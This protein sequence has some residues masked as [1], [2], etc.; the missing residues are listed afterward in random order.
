MSIVTEHVERVQSRT[1]APVFLMCEPDHFSIGDETNPWMHRASQPCRE[2][3][4]AEWLGLARGLRRLG[5][6]VE[7][8]PAAPG[9]TDMVF[10]R[11]SGV[12]LDGLFVQGRFRYA[13]RRPESA[14]VASWLRAF[15]CP[16]DDL[17]LPAGAYLEGGDICVFDGRLLAGW[18]FRTN[19]SA[20]AAL[21]ARLGVTVHSFQLLDPSFYHLDMCICPLDERHALV[22]PHALTPAGRRLVRE[23]VPEP[24]ELLPDEA[25]LFCANAVVVGRTVVMSQCPPRVAKVLDA[26]GFDVRCTPVCEFAKSGGAVSCLTLPLHRRLWRRSAWT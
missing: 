26:R 16:S 3:F 20:H 6:I 5:A 1:S 2:R 7:I 25:A 22:A 12:V 14:H 21:A 19:L 13:C 17:D 11:D 15:G 23:L 4:E 18:G 9:L 10:T 8:M 24:I